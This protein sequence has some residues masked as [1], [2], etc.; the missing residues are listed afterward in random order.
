ML[1][2]HTTET[3]DPDLTQVLTIGGT[4]ALELPVGTSAERPPDAIAGALR[5]NSTTGAVE[6]C[7]A[8]GIWDGIASVPTFVPK[9]IPTGVQDESNTTFT[10]TY[11][12]IEGTEHVYVNGL[13]MDS[14]VGNDYTIDGQ[15]I[16][17]S[18]S[19]LA[20]DKIR[21]TYFR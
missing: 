4:G 1:F 11:L 15:N 19:P 8:P 20:V 3:I 10:L 14:G 7:S 6:I 18:F 16:T 5:Y 21:V 9:E 2:D 17:F 12:P 13:L